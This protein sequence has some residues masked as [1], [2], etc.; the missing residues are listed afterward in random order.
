MIETASSFFFT[1]GAPFDFQKDDVCNDF[2]LAVLLPIK[3]SFRMV[4]GR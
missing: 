1:T 3:W 4:E 2:S